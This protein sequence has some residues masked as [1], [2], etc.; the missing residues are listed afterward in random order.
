MMELLELT[1]ELCALPGISGEEGKAA[2]YITNC[3][4]DYCEYKIDPLGSILAWKKGKNPAGKKLLLNAH[5]DEVGFTV[6]FINSD[7]TLRVHPVGGVDAAVVVGRRVLVGEK[8]LPGVVGTTPIHLMDAAARDKGVKMDDLY[9]DIGVDSKEEAE[10]LVSLG[11]ASPLNP[12]LKHLV[13][14]I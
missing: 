2:E 5:M 9:I 10:K 1:R 14:G 13:K 11:I 4:K 12:A 7:G 6:C 3:I 8:L